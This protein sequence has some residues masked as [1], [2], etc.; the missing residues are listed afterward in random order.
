M[1]WTLIKKER[2]KFGKPV[3]VCFTRSETGKKI[4]PH[5]LI[6][7]LISVTEDRNGIKYRWYDHYGQVLIP[8]PNLW[9]EITMP[10]EEELRAA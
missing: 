6:A 1:K 3:Q 7:H 10:T 2:P 9:K 5:F 8:A 4:K